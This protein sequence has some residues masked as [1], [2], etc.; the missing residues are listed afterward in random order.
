MRAITI[1]TTAYHEENLKLITDLT[2]EEIKRILQ[3]I[4]DIERNGGREYDNYTLLKALIKA[5]PGRVIQELETEY[6][7]L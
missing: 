7:E 5:Y 1:N 6:L 4:I 2:H 3:P